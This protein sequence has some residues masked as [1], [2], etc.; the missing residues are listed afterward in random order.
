[1]LSNARRHEVAAHARAPELDYSARGQVEM[2][3]FR[4]RVES[5]ALLDRQG[6]K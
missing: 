5:R 3:F 4:A 2:L 6:W 1:M